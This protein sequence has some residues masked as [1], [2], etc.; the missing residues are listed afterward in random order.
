LQHDVTPDRSA[1]VF[2]GADIEA[3]DRARSYFAGY[4]P[5][6]PSVAILRDGKLIYMLERR[7][8]E[9]RTAEEIAGELKAA[10]DKFCA[11]QPVG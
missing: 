3:T 8:I 11:R 4:A 7:Q 1:T 2:A 5:S 6:S 10:F 9:I